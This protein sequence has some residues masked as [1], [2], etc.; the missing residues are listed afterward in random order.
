MKYTF[1][2]ELELADWDRSI[3]IPRELGVV[4]QNDITIMNSDGQAVDPRHAT[5]G[6][7]I[8][9]VVCESVT[10]LADTIMNIFSVLK[11]TYTI[12]HSCWLHIHV[13]FP[14]K[15]FTV[16][17]LKRML[18]IC[19]KACYWIPLTQLSPV[20]EIDIPAGYVN[21]LDNE[22]LDYLILRNRTRTYK[23][24]DRQVEIALSARTVDEF[25]D[26]L[27]GKRALV[28]MQSLQ[29]HGTLEFRFFY[30]TDDRLALTKQI[31]FCRMFV[32]NML[33][34]S[35][36]YLHN[37]YAT[38]YKIDMDKEKIYRKTRPD[39]NAERINNFTGEI[40]PDLR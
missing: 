11:G 28:N 1:G 36:I 34:G 31:D 17:E 23:L 13:G 37:H 3:E 6:G 15:E 22:S 2:A 38:P 12:N 40:L 35:P 5:R 27:K 30:M 7:E 10:D 39:Y 29:M 32:D 25:F 16:D 14:E 8:N 18:V 9:T 33:T 4:D 21:L 26:A 20:K 24:S 19:H